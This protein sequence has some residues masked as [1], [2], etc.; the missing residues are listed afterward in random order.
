[1]PAEWVHIVMKGLARD[2][3]A[4][5]P[6]VAALEDSMRAVL[7]GH[8]AIECHV[9]FAKRSI[10]GLVHWVD[11]HPMLYTLLFF[12]TGLSMLGGL[13][14]EALRLLYH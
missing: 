7:D 2:R 6:S 14:F 10:N 13:A 9:T 8:V 12:G 1:M 11:R 4:R 5:I 3:E